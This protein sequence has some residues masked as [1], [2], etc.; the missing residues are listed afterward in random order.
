MFHKIYT[1]LWPESGSEVQ[2]IKKLKVLERFLKP[3]ATES[4]PGCGK[5]A[6]LK[7]ESLKTESFGGLFEVMLCKICTRLWPESD[8]EVKIIKN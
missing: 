4:S 6:I 3:C 8:S 1:R 2:I 5:R 7:S